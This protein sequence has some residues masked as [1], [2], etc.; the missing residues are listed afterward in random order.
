M[1]SKKQHARESL[2]TELPV[3]QEDKWHQ[4]HRSTVDLDRRVEYWWKMEGTLGEGEYS[5]RP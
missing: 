3:S 1:I 5:L 2:T 4:F